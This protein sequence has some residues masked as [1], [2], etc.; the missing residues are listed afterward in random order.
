MKIQVKQ[1][2]KK[3]IEALVKKDMQEWPPGCAAGCIS[4]SVPMY[5][6]SICKKNENKLNPEM[7][8]L[9]SC[10]NSKK[11]HVIFLCC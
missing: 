11:H 6:R 8:W 4:R 9:L 2:A 7:A 3:K 1:F 10:F 5:P